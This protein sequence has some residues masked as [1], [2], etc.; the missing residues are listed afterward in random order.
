MLEKITPKGR[1]EFKAPLSHAVKAG[2]IIYTSG[3]LGFV[4]D[5]GALAE[6]L[7]EQTRIALD[8]IKAILEESGSSMA[9]V[10]KTTIYVQDMNDI[11]RINQI[12]KEYFGPIYPARSAVQIARLAFDALVEI[13][14]IAVAP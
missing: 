10:F 12:Y 8:T 14:A 2:K 13:E 3:Q 4:G 9:H 1:A 7:E 6:T 11:P 5:T